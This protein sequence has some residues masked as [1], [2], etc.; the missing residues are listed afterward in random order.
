M[1]A[2]EDSLHYV[3]QRVVLWGKVIAVSAG[4]LMYITLHELEYPTN[5]PKLPG[6]AKVAP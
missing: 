4:S 3:L 2:K 6:R 5:F 1:L